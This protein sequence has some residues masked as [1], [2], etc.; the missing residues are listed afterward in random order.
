MNATSAPP[1]LSGPRFL[2][3]IGISALVG[4][5]AAFVALGFLALVEHGQE[6]LW[7]DLP[8]ALG[9][10]A[11]PWFLVLGLPVV[12]ALVVWAARALLPG[13]GGHRPL[14]GI[15]TAALPLSAGAGILVAGLGTLIFGAVLGPE[16]PLIALGG[17]VGLIA[18][19]LAR[20][21]PQEARVTALAGSFS[22]VS[23]V[24]GGPLVAG[25]LLLEA[26]V[27]LGASLIPAL[28]PGLV[29]AAVGYVVYL[30]MA[31]RLDLQLTGLRV[32]D[33]PVYDSDLLR[34]L[35]V[36][37]AVGVVTALLVIVVRRLGL[38][39]LTLATPGRLGPLLIAGAL[40]VGGLAL[41]ADALGARSGDIL[42]SGEFALPDLIGETSLGVVLVLI[43]F[44]A[45]GYAVCL[46]CGFRGGPVFPAIFL[47]VGV[48]TLA[49]VLLDVS[50]TLAVA[51]GTAAG[52]T[53][54]TRLIFASLLFAALIVGINGF[55]AVPAAVVAAAAAWMTI[56]VV[57]RV[58]P[59]PSPVTGASAAG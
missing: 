13:D 35:L 53:A 18:V 26:G 49:V 5:P 16:A 37:L 50:P 38:R 45:L 23:A 30:E 25:F 44:K 33:L 51:A 32:P 19:R 31:D 10:S 58:R 36:A 46:G 41:A 12:G 22:A 6:L 28:L 11:A 27:G 2:A 56:T 42:F 59:E 3:V 14:D 52:M 47:G 4:V 7:V 48:A 17:V 1:P 34:D 20:S 8:D 57:N 39:I 29:A 55:Q 43:I 54:M 40:A 24:F 21:G 15:N 9:Y